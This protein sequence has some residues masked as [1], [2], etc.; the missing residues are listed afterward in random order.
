VRRR[1]RKYK[2]KKAKTVARKRYYDSD[3]DSEV[4][5]E[6]DIIKIHVDLKKGDDVVK[7]LLDL[8][9]AEPEVEGK[10]KGRMI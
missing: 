10:G 5:E 3:S 2:A 8:W 7:K 4:E 1:L 6:E 9:T